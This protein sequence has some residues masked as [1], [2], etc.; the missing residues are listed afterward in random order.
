MRSALTSICMLVCAVLA[1]A[2]YP[3]LDYAASHPGAIRY[4][5]DL[6]NVAQHELDITVDFPAVGTDVFTVRM[7]QSSPGRYAQHNFAKNVYDLTAEDADGQALDVHAAGIGVWQI[8][9]HGGA[10]TLHYTLF[11]NGGD[12]TYAGIDDQKLHLNMPA[13][14]IY[15]EKL[16]DRPILLDITEGQ[17][18]NWTVASQLQALGSD[19]LRAAPNYAYFYDSPTLVGDI[20]RASFIVNS[21]GGAGVSGQ[22]IEVVM[23]HDGTRAE[24]D[25]YVEDVRGVVL[26]QQ[27]IYGE[28]P[29][30]DYGRYTFLCAYN[31]YIGGDGMEHRNSTVCSSTQSLAEAADRLIGTISHEF[32]HCWNVERIRPATLEPFD[33]S[34]AN[35]SGELWFAEGFTS[36]YD[37]LALLRAGIITPERYA[38]G[39]TGQLNYVLLSPGREHRNPI[40]MSQQAPFVDAATANDPDNFGNT[41]VSYYS[42]G[43][44]LGLALDL[45]LRERGHTLDELMRL[46]WERYGKPE[47]PYHVR[48][49]ELALGEVMGDAA[50]AKTW[51]NAHIYNSDLPDL[52]RLLAPYGFTLRQAEPDSVDFYGLRVEDRDGQVVV[53]RPLPE[54]SP[55][56]KA[57][58]DAGS[59]LVAINGQPVTSKK[60]GRALARNLP[61]GEVY[62]LDFERMGVA[63]KAQILGEASPELV[64]EVDENVSSEVLAKRKGWI[65]SN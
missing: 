24:F 3:S 41:F 59:V 15:G 40:E 31:R 7:P 8:A 36:Y 29:R 14:F 34:H 57:G 42:Y 30:F 19:R 47:I 62:T 1:Q 49:I 10:V 48:D 32:F 27:A 53:T 22:E 2:Q 44:T 54:N 52:S 23:I 12:G 64:V 56:Y 38:Q 58:V 37:D 43:A 55:L 16:N 13:C 26:A 35:Q 4:S 25:A 65:G 20:M 6:T 45:Q 28:L 17:R 60:Q 18:T 39:L 51:F 5:L 46:M 61:V 11:A 50:S 21:A 33:F 9:G 63:H